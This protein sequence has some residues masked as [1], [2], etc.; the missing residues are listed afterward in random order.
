M[1]RSGAATCVY[2]YPDTYAL[3]PSIHPSLHPSIPPS[4]HPSVRSPVHL[5]TDYPPTIRSAPVYSFL[6]RLFGLR[7]E[8]WR[9]PPHSYESLAH[10]FAR[11]LVDGARPLHCD[12]PDSVVSP[13]DGSVMGFGEVTTGRIEQ[14]KG[15]TYNVNAFVG[16]QLFPR[17]S[18]VT[19]GGVTTCSKGGQNS[20]GATTTGSEAAS[21]LSRSGEEKKLFWAVLYLA[22]HNYHHFHSPVED[23]KV[24][25]RRHFAGE[26][27][28]VF[29]GLASRLND[30]FSVNERVVLQGSW[31]GG[32]MIMGIVAAYNVGNI[33]L[34]HE[35]TLRTNKY[36]HI[37]VYQSGDV[38]SNVYSPGS[39]GSLYGKGERVGEF[40]L[41]STIVLIFEASPDFKFAVNRGDRVAVGELLGAP[42]APTDDLD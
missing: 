20:D 28:P 12:R 25:T 11:T 39:P 8:E 3:H 16:S 24:A 33:R 32:E 40:R 22:P 42:T 17:N 26:T 31:A 23:F 35:P 36:G 15:A 21:E 38:D 4:L 13:C 9:H 41:G 2:K 5:S 18:A 30:L 34:K 1:V 37:P 27:L 14:I 10:V 6:A 19:A 29:K 7:V